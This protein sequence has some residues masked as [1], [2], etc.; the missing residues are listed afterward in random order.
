MESPDFPAATAESTAKPMLLLRQLAAAVVV[1][2][3]AG[4]AA[5]FVASGGDDEY[6]ASARMA[7]T[8]EV[9]WPFYDTVRN[10]QRLALR[11]GQ[12]EALVENE[13]GASVDSIEVAIPKSQAFFDI[14]VVAADA[15]TAAS[16]A[17]RV[18][19]ILI[20]RDFASVTEP[21][22]AEIAAAEA[23]LLEVGE[24]DDRET[25][26]ERGTILSNLRNRKL[27][28]EGALGNIELV[29]PATAPDAPATSAG[30]DALII[31]LAVGFVALVGQRLASGRTP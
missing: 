22:E 10:A 29:D 28:L 14:D 18:A 9:R 8:D 7:L 3:L 5:W 11:D 23:A 21:I 4:A 2:L 16:A 19:Q 25:A 26:T 20:D 1:A 24:G 30:R 15:D 13:L 6:E 27:D 12:I 31:G 17:N